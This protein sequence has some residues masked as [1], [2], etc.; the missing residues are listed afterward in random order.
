M[1]LSDAIVKLQNNKLL[2]KDSLQTWD[3]TLKKKFMY[4]K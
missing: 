2:M 1:F 4:I 3:G